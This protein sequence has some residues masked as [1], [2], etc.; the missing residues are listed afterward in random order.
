M[1]LFHFLLFFSPQARKKT[2]VPC[3]L[4]GEGSECQESSKPI[5]AEDSHWS[6]GAG[7]TQF[8]VSCKPVLSLNPLPLT[9]LPLLFTHTQT[10]TH[11][12]TSIVSTETPVFIITARQ[13]TVSMALQDGLITPFNVF[14]SPCPGGT[15]LVGRRWASYNRLCA[16]F[17][18]RERGHAAPWPRVG[19]SHK[20]CTA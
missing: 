9:R 6:R 18:W 4:C 15:G 17:N 14:I 16:V 19:R 13:L 11:T 10:H 2:L 5:T 8:L 1:N 12:H 7:G 20:R 3:N